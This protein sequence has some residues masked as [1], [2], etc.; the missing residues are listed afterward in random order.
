MHRMPTPVPPETMEVHAGLVH[1]LWMAFWVGIVMMVFVGL[2]ALVWTLR[3]DVE[4]KMMEYSNGN[5]HIVQSASSL[6]LPLQSFSG[7]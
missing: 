2:L 5:M 4:V 3:D 1:Y 6:K 7:K